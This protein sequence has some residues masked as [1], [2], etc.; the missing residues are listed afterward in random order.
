MDNRIPLKCGDRLVF[1]DTGCGEKVFTIQKE[2]GRGAACIVYDAFYMS[3]MGSKKNVRIKE[4]YPLKLSVTRHGQRLDVPDNA[5]GDFARCKGKMAHA[6]QVNNSLFSVMG[7]T[8]AVT[9]TLDIY[10]ANHTIYI[11]SAYLSGKTLSE[12]KD[13]SMSDVI[14]IVKATAKAIQRIHDS[15]YLYLDI[16][17]ENIWVLEGTTQLVQLFDFDSLVPIAPDSGDVPKS[18]P[19]TKG[20]APPEQTRG[21]VSAL[22]KYTDVFGIGALL[23]DQIFGNTPGA[24]ACSPDAIYDFDPMVFDAKAYSDQLF[25]LLTEFFHH[26][27]AAYYGDRYPDMG[28]VIEIL[29]KIQKHAC[30]LTPYVRSSQISASGCLI[31]R[32]FEL[33]RIRQWFL[34]GQTNCFFLT[35][36]GGIGKSELIRHYLIRYKKDFDT[37]LYLYYEGSIMET[38]TNDHQVWVN[39]M[40]KNP[41]ESMEDYY[42]RKLEAMKQ[43]ADESRFVLVIDNFQGELSKDFERLMDGPWKVVILTRSESV[44][45]GYAHLVLGPLK[46]HDD[47]YRLLE[48]YSQRPLNALD[49]IYSDQLIGRVRGHTLTLELIAKQVAASFLTLESAARRINQGSIT[50]LAPEKVRIH[51]DQKTENETIRQIIRMIFPTEHFSDTVNIQLKLLSLFPAPG[52]F[53]GTCQRLFDLDSL[54]DINDLID[55]GWVQSQGSCLFLHPVIKDML[56]SQPWETKQQQ[57]ARNVMTYLQVNL[58]RIQNPH[59]PKGPSVIDPDE[60]LLLSETLLKS[61]KNIS[62]FNTSVPYQKLIY[63]TISCMSRSKEDFILE[64]GSHLLDLLGST[65]GDIQADVC[66]L[67]VFL[68]LGKKDA[69]GVKK[70]LSRAY[71]LAQNGHSHYL[72]GRYYDMLGNVYDEKLKG[73]YDEGMGNDIY[74][75]LFHTQKKA[76]THLEKS[77]HPHSRDV[78][79]RNLLSQAILLIRGISSDK[80]LIRQLLTRVQSI[81][82]KDEGHFREI[83]ICG[84]MARAWYFT[85]IAPDFHRTVKNLGQAEQFASKYPLDTLDFIDNVVIP[86]A[87]ILTEWDDCDEAAQWLARGILICKS[88]NGIRPFMRKEKELYQYLEDVFPFRPAS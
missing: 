84:F 78:L 37:V 6:F 70:Y 83:M 54:D 8:N 26:T 25:L 4:C 17:P 5:I 85:Y 45:R 12:E 29:E 56:D 2:I 58:K 67:L 47:F 21:R 27:L 64:Y 52:I 60:I 77:S 88:K 80:A 73:R 66:D 76:I 49:K 57:A 35:G 74:K 43:L 59:A 18:I 30:L 65:Q 36:M 32:D 46:N 41:A 53:A 71:A 31:G 68:C 44:A 19:Y 75:H 86:S 1:S 51:K 63:R 87:N 28:L 11:V 14:S 79:A 40:E 61:C 55:T 15:G 39:T 48:I 69:K 81:G 34:E 7:L 62:V 3:H 16:K 33:N 72:W 38:I 13:F 42:L 24:A 50:H 23:Y 22:G 82:E 20:F 9:N 10:E